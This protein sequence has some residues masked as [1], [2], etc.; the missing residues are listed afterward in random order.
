MPDAWMV[1]NLFDLHAWLAG[2]EGDHHRALR[3]GGAADALRREVGASQP[4][5]L[6]A[7]VANALEEARRWVGSKTGEVFREGAEAG[8]DRVNAYALREAPWRPAA[9]TGRPAAAGALTA[10]ELEV[11]PLIARGLADKEIAA[12]LGISV[13]TAEYHVDRIRKKLGLASRAQIAVWAVERARPP[14]R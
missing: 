5:A 11:V 4:P 8:V 7:P 6:A 14:R 10:R 2:L 1:A 9:S 3:L 12:R 13:R